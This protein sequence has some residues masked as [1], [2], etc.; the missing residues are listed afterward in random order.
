MEKTPLVS[1]IIPSYNY[2]RFIG[3]AIQSILRQTV[4]DFEIVVVDDASRD[5]SCSVVNSFCDHRIRLFVNETNMGRTRTYNRGFQLSG[6]EYINYLDA[7]DWIEPQKIELQLDYF[8]HNPKVDISATYSR[9]FDI[10]G[11]RHPCADEHEKK[12]N[13]N[14]DF[15]LPTS[16]I[17][18]NNLVAS[19]AMLRRSAHQRIGLRDATIHTASDYELWTRALRLGCR[20]GLIDIPLFCYRLHNY[21]NFFLEVSFALQKNVLPLLDSADATFVG[22]IF[23]WIV[24]SEEF[25]LL[26]QNERYALLAR[27]LYSPSDWCF[28]QYTK[29]ISSYCGSLESSFEYRLHGALEQYP[30]LI[31]ERDAARADRDESLVQYQ[32]VNAERDARLA[33]RDKAITER[34]EIFS[35]YRRVCAERD[36]RLAERDSAITERDE[37]LARYGQM[38]VERDTQS[39]Q[40]GLSLQRLLRRPV[41]L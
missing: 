41:G 29:A 30:A 27:M 21:R 33:E 1:F 25:W 38:C 13:Q 31:K 26:K 15:N 17:V 34:D 3:Q 32:R 8:Q 7:D 36:A 24:E 16:W 23:K 9:F 6:G 37:A 14:H 4:Q 22:T 19:S 39:P 5:S 10:D 40:R 18:Q 28:E 11:N 20:F 35:Q 2:E 12:H